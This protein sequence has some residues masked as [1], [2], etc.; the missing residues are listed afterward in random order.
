MVGSVY[1]IPFI[2]IQLRPLQ[3]KNCFPLQNILGMM[4][5]VNYSL[6]ISARLPLII[7]LLTSFRISQILF[8]GI[9][10]LELIIVY[11]RITGGRNINPVLI[12]NLFQLHDRRGRAA[13]H[14][15][16]IIYDIRIPTNTVQLTLA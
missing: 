2:V 15:Y 11:Y 4:R 5:A 8:S 3:L 7:R 1:T 10:E 14:Y 9:S 13:S 16:L 6:F 12:G